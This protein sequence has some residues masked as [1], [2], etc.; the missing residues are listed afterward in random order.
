MKLKLWSSKI[1]V[2]PLVNTGKD[3]INKIE[4]IKIDHEYNVKL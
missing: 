4:V 3:K 1:I 2:I